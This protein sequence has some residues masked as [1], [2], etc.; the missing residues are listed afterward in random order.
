MNVTGIGGKSLGEYFA[1]RGGATAYMGTT[2]PGFP[3]WFTLLGPNTG[4]GER[5]CFDSTTSHADEIRLGRSRVC[6][7]LRRSAG[8][9]DQ[10]C[11]HNKKLMFQHRSI[12]Q[13]N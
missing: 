13:C 2:I 8:V 5:L 6:N 7:V 4:T 9:V 10:K 3:N 11:L 1:E 12:M